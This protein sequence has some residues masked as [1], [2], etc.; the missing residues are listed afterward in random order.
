MTKYNAHDFFMI[1]TPLFSA[2]DYLN[3]FECSSQLTAHLINIFKSPILS[4]ALTAATPDLLEALDR[5]SIESNPNSKSSKQILSSLIKYFIRLSTRPTPFGL[6]SGIA[7]GR[8]GNESN[9]TIADTNQHTK[10]VRPDMEWVYGLIKKI[11]ANKKIRNNLGV[12]FNDFTYASGNRIDKPNKTF[13]QLERSNEN[14]NELST[15]IRYTS[16]VKMLEEKCANFQTFSGILE[17][18][19]AENPNVPASRIEGF[20]SQL[21]E[22]E[23]LLSE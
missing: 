10:R 7:I 18:I 6:F 17:G 22:N 11:E 3:M 8:F 1:R 12:R 16:Q 5:S 9:I 20:L 4:E 15:S 19:A 14:T 2:D 23:Y 21:L 13:L